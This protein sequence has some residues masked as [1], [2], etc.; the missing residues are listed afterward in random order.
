[1]KNLA[2][3]PWWPNLISAYAL[4]FIIFLIYILQKMELSKKLLISLARMTV[5]LSSIGLIL[6]WI[7]DT[8]SPWFTFAIIL[9]MT[10]ASAQI[11]I[12]HSN[13]PLKVFFPVITPIILS[14]ILFM[15]LY[16]IIVILQLPIKL[17]GNPQ[18]V[19]PIMGM[20]LG[21]SMNGS[22]LA[23]KTLKKSLE[24]NRLL[25]EQKLSFGASPRQACYQE[26]KEAYKTALLPS[27][28]SMAGMGLVA[29][30]GMMT[31]QILAGTSPIIAVK[32]Q[33]AI[34]LSI[35][36]NISIS[37]LWVLKLSFKKFFNDGWNLK[38]F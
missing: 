22:V 3:I 38:K 23:L 16:F 24:D 7:F 26:I 34:M 18:Y 21:N 11:V 30:P 36:A 17:W 28:S 31:G 20:L 14:S 13:L 5:Q 2:N 32:Y 25:I 12:S 1:M 9:A 29:L 19:I 6:F 37:V 35:T 15:G 4:T 27:L 33:I 10:F 8:K